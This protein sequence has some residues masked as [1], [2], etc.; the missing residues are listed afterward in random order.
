MP[1]SKSKARTWVLSALAI[2]ILL[3]VIVGGW[4]FYDLWQAEALPW[5]PDPT[6]VVV[7]PFADLPVPS[8]TPSS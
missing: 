2:V 8:G 7:T 3:V 4:T 6:R 1:V 5:Q